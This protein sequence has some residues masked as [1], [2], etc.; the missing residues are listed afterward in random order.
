MTRPIIS[1]E[2]IGKA[3]RLRQRRARGRTFRDALVGWARAPFTKLKDKLTPDRQTDLFWA[4]RDISFEVQPGEVI[5]LIGHNGAGK[6]T[7]LKVLSRITPPTEGRAILRG[8]VASLL[9]VGTGFHPELSGRENI[10]LNGALLG[11]RRSE[12]QQKFDEIVE[13]S[14]IGPFLDTP[15]KNYSSGMYVRLAFAVG[16]HL[17]PEILFVDEVL[18]V[19]D[20]AFQRK[21]LSK[22]ME[23]VRAGRTILF[24]SHNMES[25][26]ALCP[27]VMVVDRGHVSERL[28]ADEGVKRYLASVHAVG[29]KPLREAPRISQRPQPILTDLSI[30]GGSGHAGV[31]EA[32]GSVTFEL[33]LSNFQD[34][35]APRVMI[36]LRSDRQ[37]PI[38]SFDSRVHGGFELS[39]SENASVVCEVP[40]LALV[41]GS[42]SID[43]MV[44]DE[45][46]VVE[47][48]ERAERL[49]V[50]FADMLGTGQLPRASLGCAVLRGAWRMGV[51]K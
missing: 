40:S 38:V 17:E 19:G 24:V 51:P 50:V 1:V 43:L 11:M 49:E 35:H 47:S 31:A 27:Q 46:R 21:C 7:L 33:E 4:L 25:V 9:E 37:Q 12:I 23:V 5:G 34:L 45:D 48:V 26:V 3:F 32:G 6:S 15:V 16:A 20:A 28:P 29:G 39:P 22:M 13:F 36:I 14:E 2:R 10:F 18:A 44:A 42:Y 30:R 41:P 8:R